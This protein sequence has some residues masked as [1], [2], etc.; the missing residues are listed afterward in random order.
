QGHRDS[1]RL[2]AAGRS[3]IQGRSLM[4]APPSTSAGRPALTLNLELSHGRPGATARVELRDRPSADA[5]A[6]DG[7]IRRAHVSLHGCV[8]GVATTR[9]AR[10]LDDLT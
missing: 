2:R 8:D 9:I 7:T 1:R 4:T 10:L 6:L 5:G 3:A